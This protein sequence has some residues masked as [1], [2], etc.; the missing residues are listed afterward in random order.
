MG[1]VS[2]SVFPNKSRLQHSEWGSGS[3]VFDPGEGWELGQEANLRSNLIIILSEDWVQVSSSKWLAQRLKHTG[4]MPWYFSSL[5]VRA[6]RHWL[7]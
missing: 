7:T 1:P 6:W 5:L 4:Q 2:V 3:Y